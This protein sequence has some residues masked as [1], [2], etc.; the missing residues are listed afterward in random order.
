MFDG[1]R[2]G[3]DATGSAA[4][5]ADATGSAAAAAAAATNTSTNPRPEDRAL[6]QLRARCEKCFVKFDNS[7]HP[8]LY[9][10]VCGI[11]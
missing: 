2:G 5:A 10:C 3:A 8:R 7:L 6:A 9:D 11:Q 1:E 4:A